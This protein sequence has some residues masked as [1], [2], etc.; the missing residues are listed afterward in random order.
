M[1][2]VTPME[3]KQAESGTKI[4]SCSTCGCANCICKDMM[5]VNKSK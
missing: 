3:N 4:K 2:T 1:K 5:A